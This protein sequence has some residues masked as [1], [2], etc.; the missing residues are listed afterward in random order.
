MISQVNKKRNIVSINNERIANIV[1]DNKGII[2]YQKNIE[3]EINVAIYDL[4]ENNYFE[5]NP[6]YFG[7]KPSGPYEVIL[8]IQD[9]RLVFVISHEDGE[10]IGEM[11]FSVQSLRRNIRDY[12]IVCES[13]YKAI[14]T[15]SPSQIE[16]LDMGRRSIHNEGSQKL[17]DQLYGK[18]KIDNE[19]ARRIFTLICALHIR[20]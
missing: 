14:R 15:A 9:N 18:I 1:I 8:R 20:S 3:R 17:S 11:M 13:Y 12:F 7:G 4:V 5:P 19:T 10:K 2:S 6:D 16:S